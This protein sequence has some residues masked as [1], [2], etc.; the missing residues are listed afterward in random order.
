MSVVTSFSP[1]CRKDA[2]VLILG[3]MPSIAS[4]QAQQY[5]AH[6]R[7]GFWHIISAIYGIDATQDYAERVTALQQQKVAV[8]D[9][10]KQCERNGSLD[11][12]IKTNS[13]I[14]NDFTWFFAA[15]PAISRIVFNGAEAEK[16][17]K[18]TV[19]HQQTLPDLAINIPMIRVPSTSPAYT[20][21]LDAKITAWRLGLG[22]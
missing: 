10:L 15:F 21:K 16:S 7:N 17:F 5:Y 4:L 19:L 20:L 6:P 13:R 8:W 3:S 18:K 12:Q 9:V 2:T 14:V 1:I 22:K 11:S